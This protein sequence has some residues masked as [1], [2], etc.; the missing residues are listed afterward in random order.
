MKRIPEDLYVYGG[1]VRIIFGG[2]AMALPILVW[3][4]GLLSS[5]ILQPSISAYYHTNSRDLLEGLLFW[6]SLSLIIFAWL[7]RNFEKFSDWLAFVASIFLLGVAVFPCK[8]GT[9]PNIGIFLL[10]QSTSVVIHRIAAI[11]FFGV[12]G[13]CNLFFFKETEKR[14]LKIHY[15]AGF[16]ITIANILIYLGS[17]IGLIRIGDSSSTWVFWVEFTGLF[18]TGLCWIVKGWEEIHNPPPAR[19]L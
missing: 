18:W 6:A 1:K 2:V 11:L 13:I 7:L 17:I 8:G 4:C 3:L 9:D 15:L 16:F 10:P 12:M 5:P 19:P 14:T